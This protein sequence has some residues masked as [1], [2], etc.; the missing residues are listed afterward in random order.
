M[1]IPGRRQ[2]VRL[3]REQRVAEI[4]RAARAVF[5]EKGY[6]EALLSDIAERADVVEGSIYRYFENKRDLLVKV[7]EDWYEAMLS[8][9]DQQLSGI[10]GTRNRLRYMVWRH[11][12][13]VHEEPAL[14]H[15]MF[16]IIRSGADYSATAVHE[17]NRK[18]THRT[19]DIVREGIDAGELRGDIPLRLVRD[20]MYGC[21]EHRTWAYLR[22]E[23]D[24]DSNHVADAIV[25][26]VLGGLAKAPANQPRDQTIALRLEQAVARLERLD[27]ESA[28]A[29]RSSSPSKKRRYL[30][31]RV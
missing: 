5:V 21:V 4:M 12:E 9:Y 20:M 23:G 30:P 25:D 10:R 11:L 27:A 31:G 3:P 24:F 6:E 18:Y 16:Q 1:T 29:V 7:I 14:C 15:L 19:L 8:D 22:G 28:P 13:T 2:A 26:L 17:L